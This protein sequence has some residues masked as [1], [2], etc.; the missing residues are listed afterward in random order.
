M[1]RP[2]F[3]VKQ[4][5]VCRAAPWE[6]QPG[7]RTPRT[8][9]GV[10][11]R[12]GVPP[13]TEF[14]FEVPEL[15]TYF[16]VFNTNGGTGVVP[17]FLSLWWTDAPGGALRVWTRAFTQLNFRPGR[18]VIEAAL[19]VPLIAF[20]GPGWYEFRLAR[21]VRLRW[22]TRRAIVARDQLFIET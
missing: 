13:G 19:S 4:F 3:D 17:L 15:W 18:G 6:G 7:P 22:R 11:H 20:P 5:V 12:Y 2:K 16:R 21:E 1:A 10:C 9:E 14:P 8:L